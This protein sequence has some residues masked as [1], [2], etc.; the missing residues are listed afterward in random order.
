VLIYAVKYS[1]DI[2][3]RLRVAHKCDRQTDGRTDRHCHS[4]YH[5]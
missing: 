4:K 3:N 1:F 5:A 2:L